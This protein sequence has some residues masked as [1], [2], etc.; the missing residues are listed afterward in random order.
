M[1]RALL[2]RA[3]ACHAGRDLDVAHRDG[4]APQVRGL[5]VSLS[6]TDDV[7]MCAVVEG[8]PIG[9]DVERIRPWC[10]LEDV[11]A[12]IAPGSIRDAR[13]VLEL[14]TRTEA[15]AKAMGTG[16]PDDVRSLDVPHG[17]LKPRTWLREKGWLWLACPHPEGCVASLAIRDDRPDGSGRCVCEEH[18]P[19]AEGTRQWTVNLPG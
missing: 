5:S 7:A 16:L 8:A 6:R 15:L 3:V 1:A 14:W 12:Q 10:E 17:A 9:I 11:A 13:H 2:S 18:E 19:L 4:R